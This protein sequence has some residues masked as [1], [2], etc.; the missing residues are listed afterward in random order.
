[1]SLSFYAI[2]EAAK[3][4]VAQLQKQREPDFNVWSADIDATF[5]ELNDT[6]FSVCKMTTWTMGDPP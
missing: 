1:M 6:Y 2:D 4:W 5:T 3:K